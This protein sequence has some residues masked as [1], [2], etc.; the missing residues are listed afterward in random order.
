M[1]QKGRE[2]RSGVGGGEEEM[3]Y[4]RTGSLGRRRRK[5]RRGRWEC[6]ERRSMK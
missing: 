1:R 5:R 3:K 6:K 2:R 4:N